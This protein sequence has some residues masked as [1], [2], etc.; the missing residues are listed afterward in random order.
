MAYHLDMGGIRVFAEMLNIYA[1]RISR[2][3]SGEVRI[4]GSETR[5]K[6]LGARYH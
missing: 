6:G 4:R 2:S 3:A 5:Q 1:C